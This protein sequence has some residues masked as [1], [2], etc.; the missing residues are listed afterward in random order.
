MIMKKKLVKWMNVLSI[1]A[2]LI[3]VICQFTPYW[4]Y[5]GGSGSINGYIWFPSHHTQ[6][7][8]YLEES[9]GT[10]VEMNDVIG[11]PILILVLAVIGLI[12]CFR[13]FDGPA[14]AIIAVIA[15]IVGLWGYLSG[16]IYSL[17]SPYGLHIALCAI[18]LILELVGTAAYVISQKQETVYA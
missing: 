6:L 4:Q 12:C 2:M 10:A 14:T 7:A 9:V 15:G 17:G 8:S 18:I 1:A 5:E 16:S 13:Y 11:M 3:L